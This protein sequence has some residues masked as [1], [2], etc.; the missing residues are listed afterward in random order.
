MNIVIPFAP[1]SDR[2][3]LPVMVY[4]HG[5]SLLY[6]GAN[7]PIFNAVNLVSQS[8]K[9]G[10]PI[11]CV[12]FNYRVGLGGFLASEAIRRELQDDGFQGCG[13]F[14]FTDQKVAFDWVQRYIATLGGD[15]DN[16]TAVGESAGGISISNQLLIHRDS[17]APSVCQDF[18]SPFLLGLSSNMRLSSGQFV[19]IS[20]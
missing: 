7:L 6:G 3:S 20:R 14:G 5:G 4:V 8:I 18:L 11:I 19:G 15:P 1:A 13:N 9:M 10:K 16:V 12:N 17:G 2:R